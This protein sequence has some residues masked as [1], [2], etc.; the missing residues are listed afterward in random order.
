MIRSLSF[1]CLVFTSVL[2]A[3]NLLGQSKQDFADAVALLSKDS[4]SGGPT[5]NTSAAVVVFFRD[6]KTLCWLEQGQLVKV[7]V[8]PTSQTDD[9]KEN[10]PTPVGEFLIGNR[11]I[12]DKQNIDWYKLYPRF[13]DNKG[14]YGYATK[15][16]TGRFAMGLHPG[17][18][19]LG[20]VTVTSTNKPYHTSDTSV[21]WQKIKK[22]LDGCKM[23]YN[24]DTFT[25][26]LYVVKK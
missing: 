2:T 14:Y 19:S 1:C 16:Q 3:S 21:E 15:T 24:N 8:T 18:A 5:A 10:G 12:H 9:T 17:A 11:Y 4:P 13:E 22:Y 25:G 26:L 7:P 20:C 6:S 23:T